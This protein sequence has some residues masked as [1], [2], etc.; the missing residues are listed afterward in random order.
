MKAFLATAPQTLEL[1]E[2]PMPEPAVNEVLVRTKAVG[3]CG[4]DI[5]LFRGDHPYTTY[6][7]IF[8]H[9]ASGTHRSNWK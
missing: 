2:Q 7:M 8:G 4:S 6:P 1:V 9:E 5:H 3:I